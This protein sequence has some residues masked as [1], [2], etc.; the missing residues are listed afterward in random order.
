MKHFFIILL[1]IGSISQLQAQQ[2]VTR[3][4]GSFSGIKAQEGIDVYLKKGAKESIRIEVNGTKPENV[5]TEISGSYL[6]IHM[7][8]NT[9]GKIDVKVYVEYVSINKLSVSSAASIFSEGTIN[10]YKY[11]AGQTLL[12]IFNSSFKRI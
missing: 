12:L 6:K 8:D 3:N 11:F 10:L 9:R 2:S 1:L 4:I 7:K 5:I